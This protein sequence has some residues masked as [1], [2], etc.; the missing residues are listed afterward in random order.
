MSQ[1]VNSGVAGTPTSSVWSAD[2]VVVVGLGGATPGLALLGA[3][4]RQHL[5]PL[6]ETPASVYC[7][8]LSVERDR[9]AALDRAGRLVIIAL[10]ELLADSAADGLA[11]L[12]CG[13]ESIALTWL[14]NETVAI[15]DATGHVWRIPING[16]PPAA[17]VATLRP[18]IAAARRVADE[19]VALHADGSVSLLTCSDLRAHARF[20]APAPAGPLALAMLHD[21]PDGQ[22]VFY[23]GANGTLVRIDVAARHVATRPLAEEPVRVLAAGDGGMLTAGG[24]AGVIHTTTPDLARVT[25]HGSLGFEVLAGCA[26]P[27]DANRILVIDRAGALQLAV[28]SGGHWPA[29]MVTGSNVRSV[30]ALPAETLRAERAR[31]QQ[32]RIRSAMKVIRANDTPATERAAAHVRL[33]ELGRADISWRLSADAAQVAG[34]AAGEYANW[35][36]L[37]KALP[38]NPAARRTLL[39]CTE[40][41][42][43]LGCFVEAAAAAVHANALDQ[44]PVP[45]QLT[46]WARLSEAQ[47]LIITDPETPA[48]PN[49][50]FAWRLGERTTVY[51]PLRKQPDIVVIRELTEEAG[52]TVRGEG[53][54]ETLV[55]SHAGCQAVPGL[56]LHV[57]DD[58][59]DQPHWITW[60]PT[61]SVSCLFLSRLQGAPQTAGPPHSAVNQVFLRRLRRLLLQWENEQHARQLESL[62]RGRRQSR[63]TV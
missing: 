58:V 20:A 54:T 47:R 40:R 61:E 48:P 17:P 45:S 34:D 42:L 9:L 52:A 29:V 60:T 55:L 24:A 30:V 3:A 33:R 35:I 18:P 12:D 13:T 16:P 39:R 28:R 56:L 44:A 32:R 38:E 23:G 26:D 22:S 21:G 63:G 46:H 62:P 31:R 10:G 57:T 50:T 1:P 41:L 11:V 53:E 36:A 59:C 19:V 4:G 37:L 51:Y 27:A 25:A 14:D 7:L 8:Q 43:A 6:R 5:E 2:A 15:G 49:A